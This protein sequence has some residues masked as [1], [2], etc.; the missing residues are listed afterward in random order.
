MRRLWQWWRSWRRL[1]RPGAYE[2]AVRLGRYVQ[3]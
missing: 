1:W 3:R 2:V